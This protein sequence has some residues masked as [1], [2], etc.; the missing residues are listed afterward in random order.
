MGAGGAV[1]GE[2][3]G[4][5][6]QEQNGGGNETC[7]PDGFGAIS[8]RWP[9]SSRDEHV[10]LLGKKESF[11]W[12]E[13]IANRYITPALGWTD[14]HGRTASATNCRPTMGQSLTVRCSVNYRR[15]LKRGGKMR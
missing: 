5:N 9:G 13:T 12:I 8:G 2:W 10:V 4:A 6:Q 7:S 1:E 14:S 15:V 3:Q 11:Q